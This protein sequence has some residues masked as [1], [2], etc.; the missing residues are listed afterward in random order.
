MD[1]TFGVCCCEENKLLQKT[2]IQSIRNLN[3]P[4]YEIILV[5]NSQYAVEEII[6]GDDLNYILFDESRRPGWITKKKNIITC[7]HPYLTIHINNVN[8]D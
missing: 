4:N 3:I 6:E 8:G 1:F 2:I 5:G 7:F